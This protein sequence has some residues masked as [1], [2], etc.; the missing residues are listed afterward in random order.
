MKKIIRGVLLFGMLGGML[1]SCG[2]SKKEDKKENEI[3]VE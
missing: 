1:I 3:Q 2:D